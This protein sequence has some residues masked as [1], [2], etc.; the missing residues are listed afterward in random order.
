MENDKINAQGLIELMKVNNLGNPKE[1]QLEIA[2]SIFDIIACVNPDMANN[3][4]IDSLSVLA[5]YYHLNKR[6]DEIL[7]N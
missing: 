4:L 5:K 7:N 1:N 6:L 2:D 3:G